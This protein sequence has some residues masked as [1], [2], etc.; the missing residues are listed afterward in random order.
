MPNEFAFWNG[1]LLAAI[2]FV[3]GGVAVS[4]RSI[5][6]VNFFSTD[7]DIL[8]L[9]LLIGDFGVTRW[10]ESNATLTGELD[11]GNRG[12]MLYR[13]GTAFKECNGCARNLTR[14]D[15]LQSVQI[16]GKLVQFGL[17]CL[18]ECLKRVAVNQLFA[19][20]RSVIMV[21]VKKLVPRST[22]LVLR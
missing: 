19:K 13:D 11:D 12:G 14:R 17:I 8:P 10:C 9:L 4:C 2:L 1:L 7:S 21:T 20:N 6:P 22:S 16:D 18:I 15:R 3:F 5:L